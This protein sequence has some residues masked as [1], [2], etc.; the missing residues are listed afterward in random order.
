MRIFFFL[1]F[2][3]LIYLPVAGVS[4][5]NTEKDIFGEKGE[6][7]LKIK[8][9]DSKDISLLT[10]M[11]S[12]DWVGDS[13]LVAYANKKQFANLS[14]SG[15]EWELLPH[16]NEGFDPLMLNWEQ[17]QTADTWDYYP[18]Y[19]A[20]VAM[21]YQFAADYPDICQVW[22]IGQTVQGRD[23]LVA[24]ISDQ[25]TVDEAEPEFFY[26]S[27]MHGDELTGY[28]LMLRLI[29][30]LVT[31]YGSNARIT[32][33]VDGM[34]IFINPLA[35]PDGTYASGNQ[36]VSGATRYNANWVDLNRNYPD[37]IGG[38]HPD[39][40]AW[41]P[42]TIAFMNFAESRHFV[43]GANFHGGA[44]VFNY[45][46]DATYALT[47]DDAWWQYTG[48]QYADTAQ[49]WSPANYMNGFDDGITNGAAWYL[50]Y[51]GRQDYMNYYHQC[52]EVTIE[53]SLTKL[54]PAGTLP[55]YWQYN[56]RSLLNYMEEAT[57]GVRGMITD[58]V[59]GQPLVA[60]VYVLNHEADSSMVFSSPGGNY[61]RF[62]NTGNWDIRYSA[63]CYEPVVIH[64]VQV[65][66]GQAT[67][68]NVALQPA[69]VDFTAS[70]T[71]IN[72]GDAVDFFAGDCQPATAW[73]WTF[74]GGTP[75]TST[76]QNPQ[77][78]VYNTPGNYD[79]KLVIYNGSGSDSLIKQDYI[80]VKET[81]LMH[82][83]SVTT[84]DA[85]FYDSGGATGTYSN[86]EYYQLTIYPANPNGKTE[87]EFLEFDIEYQSNCNYDWMMIFDGPDGNAPLVGMYCGTNSP[88]TV[89][90]T[91]GTGAL[92]VLFSSDYGVTGSGWKALVRCHYD[93]FQVDTK[94]FLEGPY[95][96]A[97]GSMSTFL[98]AGGLIPLQQP[99]QA[100]PWNYSGNESV[101]VMPQIVVDWVLL[102]L[103]D[104]ASAVV[105]DNSTVVARKAALLTEG[106][107]I[108]DPATFSPPEFQIPVNQQLFVVVY[109]RNHLPVISS[110]ALQNSGN[111]CSWDFTTSAGQAFG[112]DAL[113]LLGDGNFGLISGDFN[114]DGMI[115]D[116]DRSGVWSAEAGMHGYLQTDQ[117][118]D[119][120]SGNR[121]K[122]DYWNKNFG[123]SSQVPQ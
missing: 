74:E 112:T 12:V 101:V 27:S 64:D 10:G 91:H 83:G 119:G 57:L 42:E 81:V 70:Q 30:T 52:R 62:L 28:I 24:K 44:E 1:L 65:V 58:A 80:S 113:N 41:Q 33:L 107:S 106:G 31:S 103:R 25:V 43:M 50:V 26:T 47:A 120:E 99:F 118:F 29:D 68:L 60:E 37:R 121:D 5:S 32:S 104:A 46:W 11:V 39:G 88:G 34:E 15:Y 123:K 6:V 79:V 35:N 95:S 69:P 115:D 78:I 56:R 98:S 102:E 40:N 89:L 87:M 3:S 59:T 67:V 71:E 94:L 77:N 90:S 73:L 48:H 2:F 93:S 55:D 96:T 117:N 100:A 122:N 20:Y 97:T 45:P 16:P 17:I 75:S 108:V 13:Y 36:T 109:C 18:T 63:P 23:L 116:S 54:P 61:H 7:C 38:Q 92:T 51:G 9:S 66:N 85:F 86:N 105:A 76:A 110:G 84:C 14:E 21:M 8:I 114:S 4:Q 111:V 53:L 72:P 19:D 82:N 49:A 22:S